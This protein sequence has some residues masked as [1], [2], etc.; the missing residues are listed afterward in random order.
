MATRKSIKILKRNDTY[1]YF[2]CC[3]NKPFNSYICINCLSI[4]H[5]SCLSRIK[6]IEHLHE[7][8][9]NCCKEELTNNS[10]ERTIQGLEE[11]SMEKSNHI[12]KLKKQNESLLTEAEESE[13][14]YL[15]TIQQ[16]E[17][18]I[19]S[20]KNQ[21]KIL[22]GK[23]ENKELKSVEVQTTLKTK[24]QSTATDVAV[25]VNAE[26]QTTR[27]VKE[28]KN[29]DKVEYKIGNDKEGTRTTSTQYGHR[30]ERTTKKKTTDTTKKR[31]LLIAGQQGRN[32]AEILL[33]QTTRDVSVQSILKPYAFDQDLIGTAIANSKD[34]SKKDIIILWP[35]RIVEK[36]NDGI[37]ALIH[38]NVIIISEPYKGNMPAVNNKIYENNL[39]FNKWIYMKNLKNVKILD[40]N[41]LY[42]NNINYN[43][44]RQSL[45]RIN[46]WQLCRYL[47]K[48]LASFDH[49]GNIP[50][51]TVEE[52]RSNDLTTPL[53][54]NECPVNGRSLAEECTNNTVDEE[55]SIDLTTPLISV[56]CIE[57]RRSLAEE[58]A[59]AGIRTTF[60]DS[61]IEEFFR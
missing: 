22:Q 18:I 21:I 59:E 38:T 19:Q 29:E 39:R 51:N 5:E 20:L 50:N 53:T 47:L 41:A 55:S 52:E 48:T 31:V 58:L 42:N 3:K 23:I 33:K 10:L 49:E 44:N 2:K 40:C 11:E 17:K 9:I 35:S 1:K 45:T 37:S 34:F 61:Q 57:N 36:L 46:K 12:L 13:Q 7:N 24:N 8:K 14:E 56:G 28:I 30:F 27:T 4:Y 26:V 60:T 15:K 16:Q 43:L 32:L 54:N 25:L 6:N